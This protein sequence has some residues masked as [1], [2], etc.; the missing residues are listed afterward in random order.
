VIFV[1]AQ[2]IS[3]HSG[4]GKRYFHFPKTKK[5]GN[6]SRPLFCFTT[7]RPSRVRA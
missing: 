6:Y 5:G 1:D 7:P 4:K 3:A 2:F